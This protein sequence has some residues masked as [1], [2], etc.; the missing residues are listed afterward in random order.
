MA[1]KKVKKIGSNPMPPLKIPP[2][3]KVILIM[4]DGTIKEAE[5]DQS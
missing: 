1:W 4:P 3:A 5:Y 2:K